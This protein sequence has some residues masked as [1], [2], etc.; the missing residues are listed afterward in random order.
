MCKNFSSLFE[1]GGRKTS[2]AGAKRTYTTR[3]NSSESCVTVHSLL[4]RYFY[5]LFSVKYAVH[6]YGY[7]NEW[8][9]NPQWSFSCCLAL[10]LPLVSLPGDISGL[11]GTNIT[12]MQL[13]A[14]Q[15]EM[16]TVVG[17]VKDSGVIDVTLDGEEQDDDNPAEDQEKDCKEAQ[18]QN[19]EKG[20]S[21]FHEALKDS[22]AID[23]SREQGKQDEGL[24]HDVGYNSRKCHQATQT[25]L[26]TKIK[27]IDDEE[28]E[29]ECCF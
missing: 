11:V 3:Q 20:T 16:Q 22:G 26:S 29:K 13:D 17:A 1:R 25:E 23:D 4:N 9:K 7:L 28:H 10:V 5:L 27:D 18:L 8:R 15:F 14:G 6:L 12:N 2:K 19:K 24:C 21:T